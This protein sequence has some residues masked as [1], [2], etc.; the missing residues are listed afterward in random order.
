[1]GSRRA[2]RVFPNLVQNGSASCCA[3]TGRL[4][5]GQFIREK[6]GET[7]EGDT[8]ERET[9]RKSKRGKERKTR[10]RAREISDTRS[11]M[12]HHCK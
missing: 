10:E 12:Q 7:G 2:I 8:R 5:V 1:M 11:V 9:K 6:E 4:I 3:L